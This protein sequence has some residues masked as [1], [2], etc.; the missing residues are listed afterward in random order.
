MVLGKFHT[1]AERGAR[2]CGQGTL[3]APPCP[4]QPP[5]N[6]VPHTPSPPW[7]RATPTG[8]ALPPGCWCR[9][10]A[11][12]EQP[13]IPGGRGAGREQSTLGCPSPQEGTPRSPHAAA[14]APGRAGPRSP[15]PQRVLVPSPASSQQAASRPQPR[16][17]GSRCPGHAPTASTGAVSAARRALPAAAQAAPGLLRLVL[18][19]F[20]V[21]RPAAAL[22]RSSPALAAGPAARCWDR[23]LQA[24]TPPA[25]PSRTL[26]NTLRYK[27]SPP[28]PNPPAHVLGGA[29]PPDPHSSSRTPWMDTH[30]LLAPRLPAAPGALSCTR[31]PELPG[32]PS[33]HPA[34]CQ[35]QPGSQLTPGPAPSCPQPPPAQASS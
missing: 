4:I 34:P 30:T 6:R 5:G 3:P 14:T 2:S 35:P 13:E 25:A 11:P 17:A 31:I 10:P 12:H 23:P 28:K 8:T 21:L 24:R 26:P 18:P 7:G 20:L 19:L 32:A 1:A 16:T 29:V 33:C 15:Q 9:V 22:G 27:T